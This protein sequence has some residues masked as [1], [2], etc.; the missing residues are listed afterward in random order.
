MK[1]MLCFSK[2]SAIFGGS[3]FKSYPKYSKTSA[4]PDTPELERLP[5]FATIPPAAA[6]TK[7]AVVE[8]LNVFSL[9]PPVP[10]M[11]IIVP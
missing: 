4:L 2:I 1:Q 5:C 7:D 10:H 6:T 11:S 3:K 9:S 8:M